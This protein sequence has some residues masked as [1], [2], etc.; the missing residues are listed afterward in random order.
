[1]YLHRDAGQKDT[2]SSLIIHNINV[3]PEDHAIPG[4]TPDRSLKLKSSLRNPDSL[5]SSAGID[6]AK[7]LPSNSSTR[8]V[9][10]ALHSLGIFP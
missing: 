6:P 1:M 3:L 4:R 7:S 10:R 9:T 2:Y 8:R 5:E